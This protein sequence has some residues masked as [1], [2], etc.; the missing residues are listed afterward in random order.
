MRSSLVALAIPVILL[1][2]SACASSGTFRDGVYHGSEARYRVER[3]PSPWS[4]VSF[5][6]NDLAWVAPEGQVVAVNGLCSEHGDPSLKVLT[7]HM[8]LGFE[9]RVVR[10]REELKL[11]GR[12]AL[13]T[14]AGASL[15]GVPV[16]LELTVLKK[17]G[18]VYDLTYTAPP[19]AFD[20]R[21]AEYRRLVEG[22]E[23]GGSRR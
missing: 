21:L 10:T 14:R 9:D 5:S 17:D 11:A 22:F 6:G 20:G 23:A 7:D 2:G 19:S 13:R 3:L 4:Q 12:A 8:L 18:C 16:E 1:V 15:D